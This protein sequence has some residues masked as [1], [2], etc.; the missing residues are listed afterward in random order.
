M[1]NQEKE[2]IFNRSLERALQ[3]LDTFESERKELGLAQLAEALGLSKATVLRLCATL[4]KYGYL[5][6]NPQ[7]K[8]YFLGIK[9]F[10]LG[11][12]VFSTFSL[13][14]IT[15]PF[16]RE[17]QSK[18]GKTVF[19]GIL[20][21]GHLLYID[22]REDPGN[23]IRFTSNIG[24]R[25]PPYWGM[26]G[27]V[28][29]AYLPEAEIRRLLASTPLKSTARKSITNP[30]EFR[31]WL[32]VIKKQGFVVEAETALEGIAGVAAPVRDFKGKVVA[33]IGVSFIYS[34]VD[35]EAIPLMVRQVTETAAAV[36]KELGFVDKKSGT[37][38]AYASRKRDS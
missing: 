16:L 1:D 9:L 15:D 20:R 33:A 34:S 35:A 12:I 5:K 3:I 36:S 17:L 6:Q 22:K 25:R 31:E 4:I 14:R 38:A 19:L 30:A 26:L 10:Q 27:P 37:T 24:T 2:T 7:S 28:L 23:A 32:K 11:S 18:S 21:D 29:M 13:R 8:K